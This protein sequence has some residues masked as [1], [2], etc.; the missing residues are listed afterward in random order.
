MSA[1]DEREPGAEALVAI[2][3]SRVVGFD[4]DERGT[5][6]PVQQSIEGSP[7]KARQF[8]PGL[9]SIAWD[10]GFSPNLSKAP[11]TNNSSQWPVLRLVA[12]EVL[13]HVG[14]GQQAP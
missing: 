10:C 8:P 7:E 5:T 12:E 14:G 2:S 9:G 4:V 6:T 13:P 3:G 11:P 1:T